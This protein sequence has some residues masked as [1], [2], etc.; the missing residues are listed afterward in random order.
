MKQLLV[1]HA[2]QFVGT[3]VFRV[4]IENM[5]SQRAMDKIGGVR[6][7]TRPGVRGEANILFKI[8]R[9]SFAQASAAST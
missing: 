6:S 1:R 5:R 8:T 3:V 7:G 4:G 9:A 2:L